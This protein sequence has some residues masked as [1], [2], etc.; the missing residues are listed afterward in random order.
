MAQT[1]D[2]EALVYTEYVY[3]RNSE[4][5]AYRLVQHMK[6]EMEILV[7]QMCLIVERKMSGLGCGNFAGACSNTFL[8]VL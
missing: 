8:L 6:I 5:L 7:C 3:C 4:S 1:V 2:M